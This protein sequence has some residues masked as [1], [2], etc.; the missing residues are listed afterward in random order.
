M[1][2]EAHPGVAARA[3][4]RVGAPTGEWVPRPARPYEPGNLEHV[5]HGARSERLVAERAQVV[6]QNLLEL[7]PW[8]DEARFA[9]EVA[10]F[11]RCESQA[12]ML[13]EYIEKLVSESGVGAVPIRLWESSTAK[14]RLASQTGAGLGLTPAGYAELRLLVADGTRAEASLAGLMEQGREVIAAREAR[15]AAASTVQAFEGTGA[16]DP[17]DDQGG[18]P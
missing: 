12:L 16:A 1:T 17:T 11:L 5:T 9:P 14:E 10:R 6:R 13:H 7:C 15:E 3:E 4:A 8:L 2:D 18:A